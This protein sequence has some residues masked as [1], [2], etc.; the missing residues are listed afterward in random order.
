MLCARIDVCTHDK[1]WGYLRF[2]VSHHTKGEHH[3]HLAV[4][5]VG[6]DPGW[7]M[8]QRVEAQHVRVELVWRVFRL[9]CA[10][11]DPCLSS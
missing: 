4:L 3:R 2:D 1:I 6:E 7:E 8:R 11:K 10:S 5:L 9:P